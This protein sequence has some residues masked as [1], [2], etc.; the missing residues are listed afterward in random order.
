MDSSE[1]SD[2]FLCSQ[3][4]ESMLDGD[5]TLLLASQCTENMNKGIDESYVTDFNDTDLISAAQKTDN[6]RVQPQA[7][8]NLPYSPITSDISDDNTETADVIDSS[9]FRAPIS[10]SEMGEMKLPYIPRSTLKKL[11]WGRALFEK[12]R[13]SRNSAIDSNQPGYGGRTKFASLL[14]LAE[15]PNVL[16]VALCRF[17]SE[18][19]KQNG[20]DYPPNTVYDLAVTIQMYLDKHG[21]HFKF[22]DDP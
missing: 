14:N 5:E 8:S 15:T 4:V 17:I 2:L 6:S 20:E 19:R 9:R 3:D 10:D 7:S 21:F 11:E 13:V 16:C 18:V 1:D 12:W 22:F